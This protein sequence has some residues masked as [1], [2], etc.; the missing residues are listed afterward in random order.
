MADSSP[1]DEVTIEQRLDLLEAELVRFQTE[2]FILNS[3]VQEYRLA[4][5][6]AQ[7]QNAA[8]N[9]QLKLAIQPTE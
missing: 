5:S 4:L 6:D 3:M 8:L 7:F 1:P 9:G 2:N